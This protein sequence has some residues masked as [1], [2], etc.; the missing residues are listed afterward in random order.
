[1]T[2]LAN[3]FRDLANDNMDWTI[4]KEEVEFP[5]HSPL[6]MARLALMLVEEKTR[7][8]HED[9][10]WFPWGDLTEDARIRLRLE[11]LSEEEVIPSHYANVKER[12]EEADTEVK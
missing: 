5:S 7:R 12:V 6:T 9:R 3:T 1:M 10:R 4:W 11:I 8:K 2:F